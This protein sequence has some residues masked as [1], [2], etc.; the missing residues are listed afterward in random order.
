MYLEAILI[1]FIKKLIFNKGSHLL[2][3][4]GA[5]KFKFL[6]ERAVSNHPLFWREIP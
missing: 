3:G 6:S 2:I 4:L 5:F 1:G